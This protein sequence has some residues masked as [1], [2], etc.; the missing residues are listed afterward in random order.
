[1]RTKINDNVRKDVVMTTRVTEDKL[2]AFKNIANELGI[3][4]SKLI[5]YCME[6]ITLREMVVTQ[7]DYDRVFPKRI[8]N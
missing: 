6:L 4:K 3:D 5:C 8:K 2:D 1:M 7:S